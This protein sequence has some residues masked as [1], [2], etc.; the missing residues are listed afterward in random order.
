M[1]ET[2]PV[3]TQ[4]GAIEFVKGC[5]LCE[6]SD[7]ELDRNVEE[8]ARWLYEVMLVDKK[9]RNRKDVDNAP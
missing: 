6:H 3:R 2:R 1:D 7:P 5:P 8:F 4:E 9:R